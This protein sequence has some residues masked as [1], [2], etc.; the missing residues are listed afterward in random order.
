MTHK[1]NGIA[2]L[3][4]ITKKNKCNNIKLVINWVNYT[5]P[6]FENHLWQTQAEIQVWLVMSPLLLIAQI[7]YLF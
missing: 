7:F 1:P 5:D 4:Q 6:V 3:Y 2:Q